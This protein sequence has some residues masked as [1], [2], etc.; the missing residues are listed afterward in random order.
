MAKLAK[1]IYKCDAKKVK[2]S[3]GI[4][5]DKK[6]LLKVIAGKFR[7]SIQCD[8]FDFKYNVR[9]K[10]VKIMAKLAKTVYKCDAKKVKGSHGILNDRRHVLPPFPFPVCPPRS[11]MWP[12]LHTYNIHLYRFSK[13]LVD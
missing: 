5:N 6:S 8:F 3:H 11:R 1:T 2:G 13:L 12:D 10:V 9:L 4:L 7:F